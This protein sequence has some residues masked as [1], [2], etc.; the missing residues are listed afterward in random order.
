MPYLEAWVE[1][2]ARGANRWEI[3]LAAFKKLK[4]RSDGISMNIK[5]IAIHGQ[6][7][8]QVYEPMKVHRMIPLLKILILNT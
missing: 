5:G 8:L 2:E 1:G 7:P 3:D 4:L 6:L